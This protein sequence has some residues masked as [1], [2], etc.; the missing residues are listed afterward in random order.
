MQSK[1]CIKCNQELDVSSFAKRGGENYLRTECKRCNNESTKIRKILR[2][3]N[4]SP[5]DDY[6][7]PIC[8]RN[9]EQCAGQGGKEIPAWVIDHCH[10]TNKFRGWLCHKCN[11]SLGGFNDS[12]ELLNKAIDYLKNW[13]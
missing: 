9:N 4:E 5:P 11:R 12:I 6:C 1:K 13:S 3:Q 10:K 8:G 2:Q 7:C